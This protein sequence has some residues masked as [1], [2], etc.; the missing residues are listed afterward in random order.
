MQTLMKTE[1]ALG[2]A[3]L[4]LMEEMKERYFCDRRAGRISHL[5]RCRR[6]S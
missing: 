4:S 5:S 1:R 6:R 2:L 3:L